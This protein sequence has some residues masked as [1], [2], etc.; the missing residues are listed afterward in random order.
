MHLDEYLRRSRIMGKEFART[1]SVD[2]TTVSRIRHGHIWPCKR[3]ATV[4][5]QASNG[6]VSWDAWLQNFREE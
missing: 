3:L 1:I 2:P 4:I 6:K 5:T